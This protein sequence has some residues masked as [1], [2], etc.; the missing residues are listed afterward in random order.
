MTTMRVVLVAL[1]TAVAGALVYAFSCCGPGFVVDPQ[2]DCLGRCRN[3]CIAQADD[4]RDGGWIC[5]GWSPW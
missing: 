2:G 3:I 1:L 5:F 4:G